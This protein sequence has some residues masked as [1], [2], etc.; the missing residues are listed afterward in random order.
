MSPGRIRG[1]CRGGGLA[2]GG[3]GGNG[4]RRGFLGRYGE[5]PRARFFGI[6][7]DID[8]L[9]AF[10]NLHAWRLDRKGK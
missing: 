1:C 6:T 9:C 8:F 10:A 3:G 7:H 5:G 4:G 2:D